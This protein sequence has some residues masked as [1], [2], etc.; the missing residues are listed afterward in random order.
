[1][2]KK[3]N[4]SE[5][6]NEF[7]LPVRLAA[8][9]PTADSCE[10]RRP[11]APIAG[12]LVG[13][14]PHPR[15]PAIRQDLKHGLL[16]GVSQAVNTL[17]YGI[18]SVRWHDFDFEFFRKVSCWDIQKPHSSKVNSRIIDVDFL[19]GYARCKYSDVFSFV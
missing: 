4:K 16:R 10:Q 19:T 9:R 17:V 15:Y 13:T 5:R 8:A 14:N 1:M 11:S 12:V 6:V 3:L 18:P 2:V 7:H